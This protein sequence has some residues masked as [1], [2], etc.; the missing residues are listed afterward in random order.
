MAPPS[1]DARSRSVGT[2]RAA[3]PN[4]TRAALRATHE[5]AE[6]IERALTQA[7]RETVDV[8]VHLQPA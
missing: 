3:I 5:V 4:E 7:R 2:D 1:P 6:R 8:V